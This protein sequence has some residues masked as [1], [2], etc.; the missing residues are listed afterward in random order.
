MGCATIPSGQAATDKVHFSGNQELSDDELKERLATQ[1]TSKFL[2]VVQGV[3]FDYRIFNRFVLQSDLQ[4]VERIYRARGFYQARARAGR[5][6]YV[7]RDHVRVVI[8]VEEGPPITL[9]KLE[10]RG[11]DDLDLKSREKLALAVK[12]HVE[13]KVRFD[14]EQFEKAEKSL[15]YELRSQGYA[16]AQVVRSAQVD[17]PSN[18]AEATLEVKH[19][20]KASYGAVTFRGLGDLPQKKVSRALMIEP[21]DTY[22]QRELDDAQQ[23]VLALGVFSSVQIRPQL[24]EE[25]SGDYVVPLLVEVEKSKLHTV[26]LG[27]GIQLDVIRTGFHGT[28]AWKSQNFFGGLRE[29]E[30]EG[31]PGVVLYPTRLPEFDPPTDLLPFFKLRAELKQPGFFEGRTN[32][33]VRGEFEMYPL[34]LSSNI[35]LEAPVLGYQEQRGTVGL[36]RA[37][38]RHLFA[39]PSYTLQNSIP[40]AYRGQLDADL[41]PVL[42]SAIELFGRLDTRDSLLVPR[43]GFAFSSGLQ[44]A[45]LGGD[46]K[47]LRIAPEVRG[48]LPLTRNK[49]WILAARV[50]AGVLFPQ[51]YGSTLDY[52]DGGPPA[53]SDRATWVRD[54]QISFFRGFFAG[55]PNSN[56]GY[57]LRGIGPHGVVPFYIPDLQGPNVP[58]VCA[59]N[60]TS[61]SGRCILP[62]GGQTLWEFSLELRYPISDPLSGVAFCDTADVAPGKMTFRFDR[63]HLSCGLGARYGTPIGPLRFDVGYRIPGLQTLND[64]S[65]EGLPPNFFGLPLALALSIGEAF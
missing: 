28:A 4:R 5:I 58:E 7:E 21:G 54:V 45:G 63:P 16:Y 10:M 41:H 22:S 9:R 26:T 29:L 61:D 47:D 51:N 25:P 2:G 64:D 11:V 44:F 34:L 57:A 24:R 53:G 49:K 32:A 60:P 37:F 8:E 36:A 46:V 38:G 50:G 3:F 31:K 1:E 17:V 48:F 14:E 12:P 20:E 33:F 39:S 15:L 42:I 40:F 18:Y 6:F 52:V 62:I 65:G 30:L 55:G 59:T 23:A 13:E 56:R 27:A 35:D 43:G 19:F